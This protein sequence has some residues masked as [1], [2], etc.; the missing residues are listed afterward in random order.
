MDGEP[1]NLRDTFVDAYPQ[2][3]AALLISRG[4]EMLEVIADA[5]VEGASVLD[6]LLSTLEATPFD[7]QRQSPLELFRE[8]LRPVGRA[9]DTAGVSAPETG[10]GTVSIV[11]WDTHRLSPAS[12]SELGPVA[13]E[14][15]LRWGV[16]K[17]RAMSDVQVGARGR[18]L[19]IWCSSH[20]RQAIE[21]QATLAGYSLSDRPNEASYAIVDIDEGT[22]ASDLEDALQAGHRTIVYG[23]AIDDLHHAALRARG[24]WKIIG[25]EQALTDLGVVLPTLT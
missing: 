24:V 21:S 10:I 2:W 8:A 6:G 22:Y 15:H 13:H 3:V 25:R 1:R 17:A 14:A 4:I 20:D 5:I 19:A 7:K 23:S 18:S 9:L 16:A 12:S 11:A